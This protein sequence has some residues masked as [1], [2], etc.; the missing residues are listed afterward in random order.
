MTCEVIAN[1]DGSGEI[2]SFHSGVAEDSSSLGNC[3]VST[4]KELL[5]VR[6]TCCLHLQGKAG[7]VF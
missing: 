1:N 5:M 6:G 2:E 3:A 4:S 7:P